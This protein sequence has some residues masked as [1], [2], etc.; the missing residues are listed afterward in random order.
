M[1]APSQLAAL[2]MDWRSV[3]G[4]WK[5]ESRRRKAEGSRQQTQSSHLIV[6]FASLRLCV[7]P[8][9]SLLCGLCENNVARNKN[10][11]ER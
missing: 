10:R 3:P 4:E 1:F 2:E 11:G 7:R 8:S 9:I 5:A 6:V